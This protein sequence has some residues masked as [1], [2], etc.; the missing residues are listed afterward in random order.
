MPNH[1]VELL[2]EAVAKLQTSL[3]TLKTDIQWLKR[4]MLGLY[5]SVGA[6]VIALITSFIAHK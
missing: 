4:G 6:G 1:N 5:A 2:M 3:A